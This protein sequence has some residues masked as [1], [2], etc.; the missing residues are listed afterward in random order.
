MSILLTGGSGFIGVP[1]TK[2]LIQRGYQVV[3][4][5]AQPNL[6]ALGEL[7]ERL[8]IVRGDVTVF[9]EVF[10]VVKKYK[11]TDVFHLAAILS[12]ACEENPSLVFEINVGGTLNVLEAV[13]AGGAKK[14]IF[15]SSIATYGSG[16]AVPVGED[17]RQEPLS[18]Y[19]ATKVFCELLGLQFS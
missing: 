17:A 9:N 8:R 6:N 10:D 16:V 5:D 4:F 15:P 13:R 2:E 1:L 18:F 12:S 19:G 3:V 11:V 14:F 7:V